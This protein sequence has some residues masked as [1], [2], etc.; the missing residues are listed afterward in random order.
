MAKPDPR[1]GSL[2]YLVLCLRSSGFA[3]LTMAPQYTGLKKNGD[4]VLGCCQNHD[5]CGGCG[6]DGDGT[7]VTADSSAT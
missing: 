4:M 2:V 3:E 5:G 7:M 1:H 6:G